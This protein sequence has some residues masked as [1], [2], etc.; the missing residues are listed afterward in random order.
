MFG[1]GWVEQTAHSSVQIGQKRP[2]IRLDDGK[3]VPLLP[4]SAAQAR[5]SEAEL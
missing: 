3:I 1:R 4:L 2:K 5:G